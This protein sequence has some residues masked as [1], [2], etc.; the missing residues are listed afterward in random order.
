MGLFSC[1]STNTS[2]SHLRFS[3]FSAQTNAASKLRKLES[4]GCARLKADGQSFIFFFKKIF[5]DHGK[6]FKINIEECVFFFRRSSSWLETLTGL[7][8]FFFLGCI[9]KFFVYFL[10]LK[11]YEIKNQ[12]IDQIQ[13]MLK[14]SPLTEYQFAVL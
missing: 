5:F 4:C 6:C 8:A 11:C 14:K 13:I 12:G 9:V 7:G 1:S 3:D 10:S 2:N